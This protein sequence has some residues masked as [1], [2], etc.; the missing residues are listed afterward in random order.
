MMHYSHAIGI[1]NNLCTGGP[2]GKVPD[3]ALFSR[4]FVSMQLFE[5]EGHKGRATILCTCIH[6]RTNTLLSIVLNGA[7]FGRSRVFWTRIS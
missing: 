4:C 1:C 3:D 2:Q 5:L 6:E 7:H